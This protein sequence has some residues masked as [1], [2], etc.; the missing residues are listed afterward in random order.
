MHVTQ[1]TTGSYVISI[2]KPYD[3]LA[4]IKE[5]EDGDDVYCI[6]ISNL[7]NDDDYI[8]KLMRWKVK[9]SEVRQIPD[10]EVV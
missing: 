5:L 7:N 10:T 8:S 1:F 3:T 2:N 9:W 6:D 4:P